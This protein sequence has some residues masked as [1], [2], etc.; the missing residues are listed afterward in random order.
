[1][2]ST[3]SQIPFESANGNIGGVV[4]SNIV[5]NLSES[6][7]TITSTI[8]IPPGLEVIIEA[9]VKV[10]VNP[11]ASIEHCIINSNIIERYVVRGTLVARGTEQLPIIFTSSQETPNNGD[12]G[13]NKNCNDYSNWTSFSIGIDFRSQAIGATFDINTKEYIGGSILE[14]CHLEYAGNSAALTL[15]GSHT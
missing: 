15:N 4:P 3:E 13:G 10:F 2:S 7:Y 5:L 12:W 14:H 8:L 11:A 1:L 6:P 9:G